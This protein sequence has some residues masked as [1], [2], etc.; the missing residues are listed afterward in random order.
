MSGEPSFA[1]AIATPYVAP[2]EPEHGRWRWKFAQVDEPP[3]CF[4]SCLILPL[5]SPKNDAGHC[6]TV[7]V[8]FTVSCAPPFP[9]E[10][11]TV[12]VE[13]PAGVTG[14]VG[15][16]HAGQNQADGEN[17]HGTETARRE[18]SPAETKAQ[19]QAGEPRGGADHF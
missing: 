10:P 8:K 7:T 9:A 13:F 3:Y 1:Q 18:D 17:Q 19:H 11:V 14:P 12:T 5:S 15:V 4:N 6:V 16:A 2:M